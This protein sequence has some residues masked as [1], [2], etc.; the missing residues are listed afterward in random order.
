MEV[1]YNPACSKCRGTAALLNEHGITFTERRY[2]DEPPTE[3]DVERV[4]GLLGIEPWDLTRMDE[5]RAKE[6]GLADAPRDR[7]A[8][9]RTLVENP[10]LI[11]RPI[12]ITAD[13]RAVIGRPP[14]KV[15][16]LI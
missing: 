15:L 1:W 5:P 7:A 3:A 12:V 9:V 16:D 14:E 10:A 8:W 13:G 6:L 4:L 2:L 11:Q